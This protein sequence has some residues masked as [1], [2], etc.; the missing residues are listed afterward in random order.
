MEVIVVP[1]GTPQP[2]STVLQQPATSRTEAPRRLGLVLAVVATAQLMVSLDLTI[3]NVALPHIQAALGFSGSNLE[4]VANAYA[5]TF[6]GL[7]LLGGRSGDLLGRRRIFIGGLLVFVVAS[8]IGGFATDQAWLIAARAVQGVGAAMAAPTALS[9]IAVTFP[10]GRPRNNAIGVYSAMTIL[11]I[12]VGL[13]AGGLL[14]TYASW[15][16]V[17]FVNVPIGLVVAAL[18]WRVLPETGRE[19]GR[20]DLPGAI[21]A[22]A[23]VALLVY[24]LS[25]AATTPNGVSHW[26]D[27]KVVAPLTAAVLLL[28]A[29]GLIEA[30][31]T[32]PLLPFR[33]LRSRDRSGAYLISLCVGT[34]I[35]GMFFFLTLFMQ[36]VWGYSALRTAAAYLPFVP[37]TLATTVIAQLGVSRI[38]ARP[39]LIAGSAVAAGGMF[40]LSRLTEHSTYAGGFLGPE[41][42]LGA[43]LGPLFVIIN[44]VGLHKVNTNDTGVASSL[45]GV[46]QQVGGSIGLAIVGTV[47][48]SA[49][50]SSLRSQAAAVAKAGL[51]PSGAKAALAKL[52]IYY[53][54]LAHGFSRGYLVSASILALILVIAVFVIR[55]SRADLAGAELTPASHGS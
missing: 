39:L 7:L 37:A 23:G 12:V 29:F 36:E 51:H 41:L 17:F 20:F 21:T 42:L 43:G 15:R 16:W 40:W 24:G 9:L 47:A 18:A 30:R 34:A 4:W 3:V 14:V 45:V 52:H 53:Q 44:L 2:G 22:T 55:V 35:F 31:S 38:G 46:G 6:G 8:L 11:G 27:A 54:A 10:E 1:P 25:N 32:H 49:V 48:W 50:A 13:V 33:L 28:C 5:V 19:T 26:G